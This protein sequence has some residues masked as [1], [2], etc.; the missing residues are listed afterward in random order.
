MDKNWYIIKT[1]SGKEISVADRLNEE[2]ESGNLIG[3]IGTV[4]LPLQTTLEIK[5]G[6]KVE[7]EKVMF[8]GYVFVET[9]DTPS[10]KEELNHIKG[11]SGFL[12]SR[13]GEVEKMNRKDIDR[14]LG[15]KKEISAL[16]ENIFKV[17]QEVSIIGGSFKNMK[18]KIDKILNEKVNLTVCIFDREMNIEV[19]KDQISK[20]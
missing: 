15:V 1:Q 5:N 17:G 3:K 4:L 12:K 8:K 16:D 14:M 10:L 9:N 18:G 20:S 11:A 2:K 13:S 19:K 7:K 6:K